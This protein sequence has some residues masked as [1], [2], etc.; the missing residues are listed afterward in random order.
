M[1]S[2]SIAFWIDLICEVSC[3]PSLIVTEAAITGRDTE[4]ARPSACLDRT[5]T[6]GT[7]CV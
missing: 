4:Q 7:F 5:N 3:D 6:Y 1:R 2:F